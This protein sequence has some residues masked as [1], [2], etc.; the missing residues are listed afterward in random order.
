MIN[1]PEIVTQ[2]TGDI[3]FKLCKK[4][5]VS[6]INTDGTFRHLLDILN[7]ISSKVYKNE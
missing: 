1:V 4:Y 2:G 3:I 7:D 6:M 5:N